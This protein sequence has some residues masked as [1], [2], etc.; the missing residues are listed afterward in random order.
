M[1]I[2]NLR[3]KLLIPL[4]F[5]MA[6]VLALGIYG[7]FPKLART[8]AR[9]DWRLLPLILSLTLV[10]Y[11]LRFLKWQYYLRLLGLRV[12]TGHS[13]VKRAELHALNA[14]LNTMLHGEMPNGKKASTKKRLEAIDWTVKEI[15]EVKAEL[16]KFEAA[17]AKY[18]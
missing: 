15:D 4:A 16:D 13:F 8:M 2:A 10:N 5:G 6:V 1:T 12:E 3:G 11:G 17:L 18:E 14:D 7:D 9:F